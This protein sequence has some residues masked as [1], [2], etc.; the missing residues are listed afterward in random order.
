MKIY[1]V[2]W[3]LLF[4]SI[5]MPG[6][7]QMEFVTPAGDQIMAGTDS[8]I[9]IDNPLSDSKKITLTPQEGFS[10]AHL[11]IRSNDGEITDYYAKKIFYDQATERIEMIGEARVKKGDDYMYGPK[12]ME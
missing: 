10:Y 9:V 11:T 5:C 2:F 7:A 1:P 4:V 3:G 8:E 6:F 12:G